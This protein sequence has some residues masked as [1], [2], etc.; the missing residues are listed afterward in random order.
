MDLCI[1][2]N[3][4]LIAPTATI[5]RDENMTNFGSHWR[6]EKVRCIDGAILNVYLRYSHMLE[7]CGKSNVENR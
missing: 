6:N 5:S 1:H 7:I 3:H 2:I 4:F